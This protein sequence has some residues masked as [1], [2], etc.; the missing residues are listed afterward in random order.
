MSV[1]KRF[2]RELYNENDTPAKDYVK[3]LFKDSEYRI[4]DNKK[5]T[6]VDLFVYKDGQ[7][8]CNL[9]CEIKRVWKTKDFPYESVQVPERKSKFFK[10]DKP[11]ILVMLNADKSA[12]LAIKQENLNSSPL[13]EV[14]N[15]YV[16]KGELFYQVPLDKVT[17]NDLL[18]VVK[19]VTNGK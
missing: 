6:G 13:K 11:T 14:P 4:V 5:K 12:Y 16:W 9:E 7:H 1:R 2:D 10:L 3:E 19:E 18:S 8:L 15:K 17:M